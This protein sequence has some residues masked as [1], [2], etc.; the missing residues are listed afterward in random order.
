MQGFVDRHGIT[1]QNM[2]DQTGEL[3][4]RFGVPAQ[5]A[6]VFVT[7]DGSATTYLGAMA[8]SLLDKTL[9]DTAGS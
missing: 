2:N 6:W 7:P 1:F 4:S 8:E 5:P 9:A 3:F